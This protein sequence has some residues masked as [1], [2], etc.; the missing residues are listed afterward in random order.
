MSFYLRR[1]LILSISC[2]AAL[3]QTS[4]KPSLTLDDF[5]NSVDIPNVR[6]APDGRAVAIETTRADWEGNRFRSDLWLYRED[7]EGSGSLVQ[8]T[9]SGHDHGPE[10]SPDGR[11]IAF[12]SD[13]SAPLVETS[14]ETTASKSEKSAQVYV[15]SVSGGESFPVTQTEGE[16]H[17]FAWSAD[18]RQIYFAARQWT[19]AQEEAYKKDWK[20]VVQFRESEHGDAI[21]GIEI[22]AARSCLPPA[23]P[24]FVTSLRAPGS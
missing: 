2:A 4:A 10:F 12:L 14:A 15:I 16:V 24:K 11:W 22:S 5:F 23:P 17:A 18:S 19:K 7:P 6:L 1:S 21:H 20:D 13:R 9:Q 3:A 8:L